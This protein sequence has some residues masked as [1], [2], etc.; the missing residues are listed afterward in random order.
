[1]VEMH[2]GNES[3]QFI[4]V[5]EGSNKECV[6]NNLLSNSNYEF[7]INSI[8]KSQKGAWSKIQKI[9]TTQFDSNILVNLSKE[10]EFII[11]LP[12]EKVI[13][14]FIYYF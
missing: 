8:Y 2:K 10:K 9:K 14:R 1:M 11:N 12:I 13:G 7:R 3:E 5:Y 6:I 4:K